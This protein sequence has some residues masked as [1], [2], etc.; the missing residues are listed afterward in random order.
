MGAQPVTVSIA[1]Y[2]DEM[3]Y[4]EY[5]YE[6]YLCEGDSNDISFGA[7][8]YKHQD[9][10]TR[11]VY[12]AQCLGRGTKLNEVDEDVIEEFCRQHQNLVEVR[13]ADRRLEFHRASKLPDETVK[14]YHQRITRL[15]SMMEE[16]EARI[17]VK[18]KIFMSLPDK[19]ARCLRD[20]EIDVQQM[21]RKWE[22]Y[23]RDRSPVPRRNHPGFEERRGN[24]VY[25][26]SK[27]AVTSTR[28]PSNVEEQKA[29]RSKTDRLS[30]SEWIASLTCYTC[31]E[32]GHTSRGC[33]KRFEKPEG[34]KVGL[35]SLYYPPELDHVMIETAVR[36]DGKDVVCLID[37]GAAKT[38]LPV[39]HVKYFKHVARPFSIMAQDIAGRDVEI[40]HKAEV[41]AMSIL[42]QVSSST[43][44]YFARINDPV[45]CANDCMKLEIDITTLMK[46]KMLKSSRIIKKLGEAKDFDERVY[47]ELCLNSNTA[48]YIH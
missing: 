30:K 7:Y 43:E 44:V 10:E 38:T 24:M 22:T 36:L 9:M 45:I 8:F 12:K 2:E 16:T 15:L 23:L 29:A 28:G 31:N 48:Q 40:T 20:D 47:T 19:V 26:R 17:L 33:P 46:E 25:E 21:L 27:P 13:E 18:Q 6:Q 34:T 5:I 14:K 39:E 41:N 42:T 11:R 37:T 3:P 1:D 32:K 35:G 4:F